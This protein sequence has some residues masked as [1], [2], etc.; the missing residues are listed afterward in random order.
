M[1]LAVTLVFAL[2][3]TSC[4]VGPK[5]A[6]PSVETPSAYKEA[7]PVDPSSADIWKTA[8][9]ADDAIRGKW[10]EI[11]NEPE[12]NDLEEKAA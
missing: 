1:P 10:W 8:K 3:L 12:L 11:F 7:G 5:Y 9:P 6:R 2:L 4:V